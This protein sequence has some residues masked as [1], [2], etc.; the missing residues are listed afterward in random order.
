MSRYLTPAK[1]G[2]LALIELYTEGD[3]PSESTIPV[4]SFLTSHLIDSDLALPHP[5]QAT[6]THATLST[7]DHSGAT[8]GASRWRRAEAAVSLVISI[9]DFEK[10]LHGTLA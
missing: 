2:L 5:P 1:I 10:L 8:P 9:S 7:A 6:P 3:V 4:L